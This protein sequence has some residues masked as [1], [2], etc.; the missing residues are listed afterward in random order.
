M[1]VGGFGSVECYESGVVF[2]CTDEFLG[3]TAPAWHL[4]DGGV[5]GTIV[6]CSVGPQHQLCRTWIGTSADDG[7]VSLVTDL[8]LLGLDLE[9]DPTLPWY[10]LMLCRDWSWTVVVGAAGSSVEQSDLGLRSLLSDAELCHGGNLLNRRTGG[11]GRVA[12]GVTRLS[13]ALRRR[14]L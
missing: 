12:E 13:G 5:A 4:L 11:R 1:G 3:G 10:S 6:M 9:H 8:G 14:R 2:E 7:V